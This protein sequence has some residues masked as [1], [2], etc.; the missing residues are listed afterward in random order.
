MGALQ[1]L[2]SFRLFHSGHFANIVDPLLEWLHL[3]HPRPLAMSLYDMIEQVYYP[4]CKALHA[5]SGLPLSVVA[6]SY[7][8]ILILVSVLALFLW[9]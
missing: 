2:T 6:Y 9:Y 3:E 1:T 4:S 7:A 8:P 5:T